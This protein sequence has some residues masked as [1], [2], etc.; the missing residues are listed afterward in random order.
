[1]SVDQYPPTYFE[2]AAGT[3]QQQIEDM[4]ARADTFQAA[5]EASIQALGSLTP[6]T[7]VD[8]PPVST[9]PT[10]V[11]AQQMPDAPTDALAIDIDPFAAPTFESLTFDDGLVLE[12]PGPFEPRSGSLQLPPAPAPIVPGL[13]PAGPTTRDIALPTAPDL[14]EPEMGALLQV[15][16]PEF[17]FPGLPTFTDPG[18]PVFTGTPP[19]TA[20]TWDEAAY[21]SPVLDQIKAECLRQMQ[22]GTGLHPAVEAALF[23]RAR[24]RDDE[25]GRKALQDA[26]DV[27]ASRG[28]ELPTGMLA[29]QVNATV[30]ANRLSAAATNREI[31]VQASE[32]EQANLRNA[33]AQGIALETVLIQQHN[34]VVQRAFDAAR[35]RLDADVQLFNIAVS[36]YNARQQARSIAVEVF[37]AEL[38]GALA[39]LDE[40]RARIEAAKAAGDYNRVQ[41]E[42]YST[43]M[44]GLR[45]RVEVFTAQNEGARVQAEIERLR[46]EKWR[47]EIEA[48]ATAL[49]VRK[50]EWE[51]YETR[52][53]AE[54]A[55]AGM[56]DAEA[57]A[58]AATVAAAE[59]RN[60]T[61]VQ[62]IRARIEALQASVALFS[63]RVQAEGARTGSMIE[64]ART[65]VS[66]F[67]ADVERFTAE[68][69]ADTADRNLRVTALQTDLRNNLAAIE[70]L[71]QQWQTRQQTL[72]QA[73][74]LQA[75][76]IKSA[77]AMASQLA[78]GAFSAI[79]VGA[80]ISGSGSG[81]T[82]N[83]FTRSESYNY[84]M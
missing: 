44:D 78:A 74:T 45:R 43:R 67:A 41:A 7:Y 40:F 66:A 13:A 36:L 64:Q 12:T 26:V 9:E 76:A 11:P 80:Q 82:S 71:S 37:K 17:T 28:F 32:L 79:N 3:V 52:V 24:A 47:G 83:S 2:T 73:A 84:Q 42:I 46:V 8:A 75:E 4:T 15:Q 19:S 65:R 16:I 31:L 55:R 77:G 25:Q 68:V 23:A 54:S 22:G 18:E 39:H 33:I 1:M 63:A 30:E 34:Q 35:A 6:I 61:K 48:W 50:I 51:A 53:R 38:Q 57:R 56:L 5:A 62:V 58:F 14:T 49:N 21:A 81:Q 69:G 10:R 27:M 59:G 72:V 29:E 70:L 20:L 60:N